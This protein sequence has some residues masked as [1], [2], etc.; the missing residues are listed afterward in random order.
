MLELHIILIA[1]I[2]GITFTNL[3]KEKRII[4]E[5]LS[6]IDA[7]LFVIFLIVNGSALSVKLIYET[8][9]LGI[10]LIL[11]RGI[12]KVFGGFIG[13]TLTNLKH[14]LRNV[15][16]WG[17]LPQSEISIYLA[18]LARSTLPYY[19]NTIFAATMTG[20]IFFEIIGAPI[21]KSILT[22]KA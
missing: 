4:H 1:I 22:E 8:R 19:G 7:P 14:N 21:L 11:T 9:F 18:V 16:G 17:L 10:A 20:V 15:I 12:G 2:T 6:Q 3:S 5:I 13:G